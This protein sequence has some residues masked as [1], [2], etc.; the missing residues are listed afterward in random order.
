MYD[1]GYTFRTRVCAVAGQALELELCNERRRVDAE[2]EG[3]GG[4][5]NNGA[6]EEECKEGEEDCEQP[7]S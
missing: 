7:S 2:V 1:A 6:E 5:D 4:K 3:D